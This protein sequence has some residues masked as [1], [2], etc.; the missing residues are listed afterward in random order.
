MSGLNDLFVDVNGFEHYLQNVFVE[1]FMPS[2]ISIHEH[3]CDH[4]DLILLDGLC[5]IS[6]L[7]VCPIEVQI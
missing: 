7:F 4:D 1:I 3:H 6:H 5:M 2:S